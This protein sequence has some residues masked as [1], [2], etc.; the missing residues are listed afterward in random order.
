MRDRAMQMLYQMALDPVA[1]EIADNNSYGF[2]QKRGCTDA[3]EQCFNSL[4]KISSTQWIL[5][6]DIKS[7]FDKINHD[8]VLANTPSDTKMLKE[9][10]KCG[11]IDKGMYSLTTEGTPQG[12]II[13]PTLANLTLDGM[14]DLLK[15]NFKPSKPFNP[16]VNLV[17]YADDFIITG[18]TKELL[19]KF[20]VGKIRHLH[21]P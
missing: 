10:L 13:S 14:E 9:W 8:F 20:C 7:C 6:G 11:L 18:T 17:R 3:I 19:P 5:E 2:R 1:E 16:K 12:G 4:A 15:K 21:L